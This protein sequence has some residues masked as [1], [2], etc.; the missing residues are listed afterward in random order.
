MQLKKLKPLTAGFSEEAHKKIAVIAAQSYVSKAEWMRKL[1]LT[2]IGLEQE[3]NLPK[4]NLGIAALNK[5]A[6][7]AA[8]VVV[9]TAVVRKKRTSKAKSI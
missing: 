1:V 9:P 4:T 2:T 7:A 5:A 6:E 8:P 3:L